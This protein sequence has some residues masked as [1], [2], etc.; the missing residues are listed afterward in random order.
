M[1]NQKLFPTKDTERDEYYNRA[2]PYIDANKVRLT[3]A[4]ATAT[5]AV[6]LLT[7]WNATYP[8]SKNP[9]TRTRTITNQKDQL[10]SKIEEA[11]RNI[12]ADIPES[13]LTDADRN[14]LNLKKRDTV[15]TPRP[16]INVV[17]FAKAQGEAGGL[18]EFICRTDSDS[19]RASVL[20]EADGIEVV[21]NVG[22][23]QPVSPSD[24][25]RNFFSSKAKFRISFDLSDAGKKVNCFVRW[26]NNSDPAKSGPWV[27][28]S[29][30]V[31]D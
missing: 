10:I 29:A 17:P 3:V 13:V 28:V 4:P 18:V 21:F 5:D 11:L 19:S 15:N 23:A 9:D 16:A 25:T 8:Q 14:T 1:P 27:A 24:C 6:N 31:T 7:N 22:G 12:Y 2:I 26:K 30:M 20:P